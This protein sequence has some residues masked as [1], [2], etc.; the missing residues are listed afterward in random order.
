MHHQT[1]APQVYIAPAARCTQLLII[2]AASDKVSTVDTSSVYSPAV[3]DGNMWWS[4]TLVKD[5][6]YF[7]PDDA[8]VG[9]V[10][11]NN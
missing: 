6:V 3:L 10:L 7:T 11:L 1:N 9:R 8:E 2:D 5:R 4:G